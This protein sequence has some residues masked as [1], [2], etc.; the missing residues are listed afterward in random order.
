MLSS[1]FKGFLSVRPTIFLF[2]CVCL[3]VA[4]LWA[5]CP[6]LIVIHRSM[7]RLHYSLNTHRKW[8][9]YPFIYLYTLNQTERWTMSRRCMRDESW[10]LVVFLRCWTFFCIFCIFF[11]ISFARQKC[12]RSMW[13]NAILFKIWH[14]NTWKFLWVQNNV[15]YII[16]LN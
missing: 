9:R 8:N 13:T 11:I 10:C 6:N 12:V 15:K 4:V 3:F 14:F 1:C 2:F 5:V 7:Y 16:S